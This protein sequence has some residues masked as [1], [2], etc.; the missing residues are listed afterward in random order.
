MKS[1][2]SLGNLKKGTNSATQVL[3]GEMEREMIHEFVTIQRS[4]HRFRRYSP[5]DNHCYKLVK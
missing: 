4:T 2:V 5:L 1:G 3:T